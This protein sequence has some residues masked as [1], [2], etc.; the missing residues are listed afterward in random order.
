MPKLRI[1]VRVKT[2]DIARLITE[3]C[4]VGRLGRLEAYVDGGWTEVPT[5]T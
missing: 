3:M 2:R 5:K 1:E 4:R